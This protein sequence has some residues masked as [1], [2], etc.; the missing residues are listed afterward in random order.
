M[1]NTNF[2]SNIQ[3]IVIRCQAHVCLLLAIRSVQTCN[4]SDPTLPYMLKGQNSPNE[5]VDLSCLHIIQFLDRIL[6]LTLVALD[7]NNEHECIVLLDL[8]HRRLCVQWP[9]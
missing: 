5:S 2:V 8:L 9:A 6:D 4:V 3:C 1:S 7:I